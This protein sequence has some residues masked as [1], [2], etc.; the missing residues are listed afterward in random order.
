[1]KKTRHSSS[2]AAR[3]VEATRATAVAPTLNSRQYLRRVA[4][5]LHDLRGLRTKY[6]DASVS[7]VEP[8][9]PI[10]IPHCDSIRS[11]LESTLLHSSDR[12]LDGTA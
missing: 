2:S 9:S 7:Q 5:A 10:A 12:S 8:S 1:M 11:Q 4:V 3:I 6:R